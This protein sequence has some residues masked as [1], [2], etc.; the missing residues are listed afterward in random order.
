M[1]GYVYECPLRTACS[2]DH[3][4]GLCDDEDYAMCTDYEYVL[5]EIRKQDKYVGRNQ[6]MAG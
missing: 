2:H 3:Q 5:E 4:K 1:T 6:E